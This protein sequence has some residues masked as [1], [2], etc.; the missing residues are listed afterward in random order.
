MDLE[1]P[2]S[3]S[4][5][6]A[7][8]SP[9]IDIS[10]PEASPLGV[11]NVATIDLAGSRECGERLNRE[12]GADGFAVFEENSGCQIYGLTIED[13]R[14]DCCNDMECLGGGP[15]TLTEFADAVAKYG[16]K[17]FLASAYVDGGLLRICEIAFKMAED[18]GEEGIDEISCAAPFQFEWA[19]PGKTVGFWLFGQAE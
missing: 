4:M 3:R 11:K 6:R 9:N 13:L 18:P 12:L 19:R 17:E 14:K 1:K 16:A 2:Q 15:G 8:S 7:S 10:G 5:K